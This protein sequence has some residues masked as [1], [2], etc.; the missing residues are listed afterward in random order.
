MTELQWRRQW[1]PDLSALPWKPLPV[2][3]VDDDDDDDARC[4]LVK[5]KFQNDTYEF[6]VTDMMHFWYEKLGGTALKRRVMV[7]HY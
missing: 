5:S 1:K 4:F 6:L 2:T 3:K 7:G